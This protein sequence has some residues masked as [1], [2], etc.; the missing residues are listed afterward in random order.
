MASWMSLFWKTGEM[1]NFFSGK[2]L[3]ALCEEQQMS[4]AQVML[5]RELEVS[6][7]TEGEVIAGVK[8]SLDVMFRS[9]EQGLASYDKSLGGLLSGHSKKIYGELGKE[10]FYLPDRTMKAVAYALA[11]ME[12]NARM[13]VIV[14]APTAGSSGILPAVLRDAQETSGA[15]M[16]QL[17][18]AYL[19]AGAVGLIVM[20]NASISG[21]KG[22]CQAEIGTSTAMSAAALVHLKGGSPKQCLHAASFAF[23]NILGLA[24]DPIAGLVEVPCAKRNGL[25]VLNAMYCADLALMEIGSLVP[26]DEIVDAMY[27]VGLSMPATLRETAM[28][29]LA[30][31][32]T[33]K[34]IERDLFAN[35]ELSKKK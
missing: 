3:L 6:G 19:C 16:A 29:G 17:V 26:F 24:C 20:Q 28:G 32:P 33:A 25:G 15:T 22:G 31:T 8:H 4:I 23:K 1:M 9:I 5:A 7:R 14:A 27:H 34:R 2:Q 12:S 13:G 18:D 11:V 10:S 21:A 30:A 35:T